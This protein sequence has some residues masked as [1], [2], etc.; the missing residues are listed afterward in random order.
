MPFTSNKLLSV[1]ASGSNSGTWGAGTADSLNE[2]VF[3]ILDD[4]LGSTTTLSLSATDVALTQAQAN[5]CMLR[6]TGTL[7]AN[8][9][10][11]PDAGVTM[12]GFYFF[13]DLTTRNNFTITFTRSAVSITIPVARRGIIFVDS[14]GPRFLGVAGTTQPDPMA[15]NAVTLFFM[16]SPPSGWTTVSSFNNYGVRVVSSGGGGTFGSVNYGDLFSRTATDS[17]T[18]TTSQIPSHSHDVKYN[19]SSGYAGGGGTTAVSDIASGGAT[20]ASGAAGLTGGGNG[21]THNIDMRVKTVD[22]IMATRGD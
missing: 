3:E 19:A 17:H 5:N 16:S 1:Q 18:L 15:R 2:G 9:V 20:T 21:H 8:I 10:I 6:L 12:T 22:V 13:E 4:N 11:S 7:L 14:N